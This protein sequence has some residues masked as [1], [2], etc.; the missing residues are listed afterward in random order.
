MCKRASFVI[1]ALLLV[2]C[3]DSKGGDERPLEPGVFGKAVAPPGDLAKLK[4]GM[5][6]AEAKA[7]APKLDLSEKERYDLIDS[8]IKKV[9][10][11][12]GVGESGK[13]DRL[14]V[15][16]PPD[17]KAMVKQAWGPGQDGT[18]TTRRCTYYFDPATGLRAVLEDSIGG[19]GASL[20]FTR[21]QPLAKMLG[22]KPGM[23]AVET[24][25]IAGAKVDEVKATYKDVLVVEPADKAK[26]R[27]ESL[28]L[29]LPPTEYE[30]Y[31]TRVHIYPENGRVDRM[32]VSLEYDAYPK[33]REAFLAAIETAWGKGIR[34]KDQIDRDKIVWIDAEGRRRATLDASRDGSYDIELEPILP[35]VAV[36]GEGADKF[37]FETSPLLGAT[38]PDI[39]KA[40]PDAVKTQTDEE[41]R[42]KR[43]ELE[44]FM[45]DDKDKL[46]ALGEAKGSTMFELPPTEWGRQFTLVQFRFGPDG[47]AISYTFDIGYGQ[48]DEGKDDIKAAL[49]KKFPGAKEGE[50]YGRKVIVLRPS[51]PK[52]EAEDNTITK[53]WSIRVEK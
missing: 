34:T 30:S 12:V 28:Y 22:A 6:T 21:Y 15:E 32:T 39:A 43:K 51:A 11:G 29:R 37:G 7:A 4:V 18:C 3:K 36:L 5:T 33:A 41:A 9:R 49:M 16:M 10:F 45:G 48:A 19:D 44:N 26:N 52:I 25:P 1:A 42:A 14:R 38:W 50:R 2:G 46:K 20:E 17:G 23:L 27:D 47:K 35:L 13:V 53:G 8:G 31:E 40:Y 24:K